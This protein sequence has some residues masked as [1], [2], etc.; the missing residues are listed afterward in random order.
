MSFRIAFK[1][2]AKS[3]HDQHKLGA[4]IVK[5]HRILATG[6][7]QLRSS[8]VTKTNTLHAEAAAILQLLK[9]R[10]LEDLS[11]AEL[12]VTRF[13]RGGAVGLARP[14]SQCMALIRSV[15]IAEVHYTTDVGTESMK[16]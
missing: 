3:E 2:A 4:T 11:G 13:T 8:S 5:G 15:G 1:Q 12:Y 6:F 10:R 9:E 16:V 14:C 7:N